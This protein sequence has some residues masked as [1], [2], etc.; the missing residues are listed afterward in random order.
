MDRRLECDS[1]FVVG[2]NIR[3]CENG[4]EPTP[5]DMIADAS[6]GSK[7]KLQDET[8]RVRESILGKKIVKTTYFTSFVA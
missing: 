3:S 8:L 4:N 5:P 2:P 7:M 6:N 1:Y